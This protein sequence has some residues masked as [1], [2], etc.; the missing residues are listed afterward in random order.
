[1]TL[2]ELL[3]LLQLLLHF[4]VILIDLL[5][6]KVLQIIKN[7]A[8]VTPF[9]TP[10]IQK[11][12]RSH[13]VPLTSLVIP[14]KEKIWR[15]SELATKTRQSPHR[16]SRQNPWYTSLLAPLLWQLLKP[17]RPSPSSDPSSAFCFR[18][19]FLRASSFFS[20]P[21]CFLQ[22]QVGTERTVANNSTGSLTGG[23]QSCW[24]LEG[25]C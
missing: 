11:R 13:H 7:G 25:I 23:G 3:S 21:V 14:A 24:L 22:L 10:F 16:L 20:S 17:S 19:S 18:H 5:Q 1:M 9:P 12:N 8:E 6:K 4:Q 15:Q 2:S